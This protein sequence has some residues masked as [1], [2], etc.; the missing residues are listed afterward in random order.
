MG[1]DGSTR[2]RTVFPLFFSDLCLRAVWQYTRPTQ[3]Q[4]YYGAVVLITCM[5]ET[6]LI[7]THKKVLYCQKPRCLQVLLHL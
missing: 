2:L 6:L 1:A 4:P 3:C 5:V 7:H